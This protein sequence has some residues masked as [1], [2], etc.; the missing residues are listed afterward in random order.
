AGRAGL[1]D[2]LAAEADAAAG[3][4]EQA[5]EVVVQRRLART[6]A[7]Q[8][9]DDLAFAQLEV[10]AMQDLHAV[11]AGMECFDL[12]QRAHRAPTA[13]RGAFMRAAAPWPR[14]ASTT[15]GMQAISAGVPSAMMRPWFST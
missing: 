12:Q 3:G 7:A 8:H 2:V 15:F 9:G 1:G 6:V 10:D 13:S 4:A 11:I 5:A 14:Y